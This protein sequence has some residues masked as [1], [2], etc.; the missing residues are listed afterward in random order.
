MGAFRLSQGF[1]TFPNKAPSKGWMRMDLS[2][3]LIHPRETTAKLGFHFQSTLNPQLPQDR[4][5]HP[6]T[7]EASW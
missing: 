6:P 4:L 2:P 7:A 3:V 1:Y 5:T